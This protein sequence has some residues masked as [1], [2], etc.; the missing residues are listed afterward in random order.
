MGDSFPWEDLL[1]LI[2]DGK[3]LPVIGHEL[4]QA[5]YQGQRVSLQRVLAE[6]LADRLGDRETLTRGWTPNFE[7]N[8]VV[9]TYLSQ[10]PA[11]GAGEATIEVAFRADPSVYDGRFVNNGWLQ[12][13]PRPWTR[14][15]W[16]NAVLVSP[17]MAEASTGATS[18]GGR[19]QSCAQG[20]AAH[21]LRAPGTRRGARALPPT[22]RGLTLERP[23]DA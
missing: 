1:D 15:V 5:D 18:V 14:L 11:V 19:P 9:S 16:D 8:D 23:R 4:V 17:S 12:E 7:L 6:R 2:E 22:G 10:L 20:A 21:V 3:V 13:L